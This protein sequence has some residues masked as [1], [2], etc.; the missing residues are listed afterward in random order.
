MQKHKVQSFLLS[1]VNGVNWKRTLVI[2][3]VVFSFLV[4]IVK[5]ENSGIFLTSLIEGSNTRDF[6]NENFSYESGSD[7]LSFNTS[8]LIAN[9][10]VSLNCDK[11]CNNRIEYFDGVLEI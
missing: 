6:N 3:P 10:P 8:I 7:H 5:V 11:A 9:I 2:L 1:W 4:S